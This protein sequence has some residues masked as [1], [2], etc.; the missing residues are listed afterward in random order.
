MAHHTARCHVNVHEV[1]F[2]HYTDGLAVS[3][4]NRQQAVA[5]VT[6]DSDGALLMENKRGDM[7]ASTAGTSD[8]CSRTMLYQSSFEQVSIPVAPHHKEQDGHTLHFV[9]VAEVKTAV[10]AARPPETLTIL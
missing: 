9:P 6:H 10:A 5:C 1:F 4:G 3:R 7:T 2:T 8:N